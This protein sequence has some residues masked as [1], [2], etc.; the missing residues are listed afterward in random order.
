MSVDEVLFE[1]R[2]VNCDEDYLQERK[3]YHCVKLLPKTQ[4]SNLYLK[5]YSLLA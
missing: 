1:S 5:N 3:P 4:V 2:D